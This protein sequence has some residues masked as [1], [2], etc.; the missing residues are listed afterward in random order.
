M[1]CIQIR[2]VID[3]KTFVPTYFDKFRC[4]AGEC[5]DTCC[6]GWE[7]D[8]DDDIIEKYKTVSG[9]LGERIKNSLAKDETDCYIF[10]LCDN[11][12]CPF[13]NSC[14][15]CDIQAAHGEEFLSK[16]CAMFPR[17]YDDF[18][19]I[20]EMGIGFG[21]P[22]AA[23]IMLGDDEPFSLEF[24]EEITDETEDIDEDFLSEIIALRA[25][26]FIILEDKDL[27]FRKKIEKIFDVVTEFQKELDGDGYV[28]GI[29]H[30]DFD[31]CI[32]VLE[33]MEYIKPERM[34]FVSSL[35]D[36]K[37]SKNTLNL[38]RSDFEKLMKYY[39]FRYFLSMGYDYD[40]VTPVKY[41]VFACIVISR[42]YAHFGT[43]DFETRVKIMYSYSKEV[44]Y[45]DVNMD[46]LDNTMYEDF[47]TG[48][49]IGLL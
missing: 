27:S 37:L 8:L 33:N 14:N 18:G 41:G 28:D 48:D 11:G 44:E 30:R 34:D 38:Y 16:T 7:A 15:L 45:S 22:E 9:E 1:F 3:I 43:P 39:I 47:G 19:K 20:R 21:C 23:R 17:F 49:L 42:I 29:Q 4:I 26:I 46:L 35:K 10:A 36:K 40:V 6:A 25:E 5:P 32:A 31:D 24:Y 12:R 13:L 2:L